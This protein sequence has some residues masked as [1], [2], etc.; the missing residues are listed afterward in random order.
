MVIFKTPVLASQQTAVN[1]WFR[2]VV[3]KEQFYVVIL[4]HLFWPVNKLRF[5]SVSCSG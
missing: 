5:T 4:K 1:L 3:K 2:A